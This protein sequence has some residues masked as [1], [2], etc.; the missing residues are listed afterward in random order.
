MCMHAAAANHVMSAWKAVD[1]R[2]RVQVALRH[3]YQVDS[4]AVT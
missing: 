4:G 1:E 3:P 2:A